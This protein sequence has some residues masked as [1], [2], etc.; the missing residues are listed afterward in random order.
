MDAP[1]FEVD[2]FL[3]KL[4]DAAPLS[5]LQVLCDPGHICQ[6]VL[7]ADNIH[8]ILGSTLMLPVVPHLP[9]SQ[10]EHATL[11]TEIASLD[12]DMQLLVYENYSKFITATDTVKTMKSNVER[13]DSR[14]IDLQSLIGT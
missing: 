14:M 6:L 3:R 10:E 11:Q 12:S 1:T 8:N 9:T 5:Q 7:S 13:M 2:H 4:L